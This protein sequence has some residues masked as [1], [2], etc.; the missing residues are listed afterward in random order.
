[1][2]DLDIALLKQEVVDLKHQNGLLIKALEDIVD[3][4]DNPKRTL[5]SL[6]NS[7]K[8]A[9]TLIKNKKS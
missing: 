4:Q 3:A 9:K 1:M 8:E 2:K 6:N 7:I 5:A